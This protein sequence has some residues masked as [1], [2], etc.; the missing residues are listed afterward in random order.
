MKT[1]IELE[2]NIISITA[3][4]HK[5]FPELSKHITEIPVNDSEEDEID[6]KN[7]EDYYHS[8]VEILSKY[9]KTHREV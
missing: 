5:E 1:K 7:L 4:I 6:I 2:Q 8:L 9:A 3:K